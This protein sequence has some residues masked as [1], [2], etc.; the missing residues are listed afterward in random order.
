[1]TGQEPDAAVFESISR[2]IA[3]RAGLKQ[4]PGVT[5]RLPEVVAERLAA[6]DISSPSL[7]L[8][9]LAGVSSDEEL[10]RLTAL[11]TV[12]ETHFFRDRAQ[13]NLLKN[14]ILP[15]LMETGEPRR[16]LRILSAGCSTG[17]EPYSI[18]MLVG[19]MFRN[20]PGWE[21]SIFGVDIDEKAI[22][23]AEAGVYTDWSFRGT[24]PS[25]KERYF[26][27]RAD[28]WELDQR[29]RSMVT[30]RA[31]NLVEDDYPSV[32]SGIYDIDL[33]VCRNVFIYFNR[34]SVER[35]FKKLAVSLS[36]IGYLLTGHAEALGVFTPG[37][38]VRMFPESVVYQ[39]V[40]RQEKRRDNILPSPSLTTPSLPSPLSEGRA[41][42]KEPSPRPYPAKREREKASPP[43]KRETQSI[44]VSFEDEIMSLIRNGSFAEAMSKA[45]GLDKPGGKNFASVFLKAWEL[46]NSGDYVNAM[47]GLNEAARINPLEPVTYYLM[48]QIHQLEC[49]FEK[50]KEKLRKTLYLDHAFIPAHLELA[51]LYERDNDAIRARKSRL[52]ALDA[53]DSMPPDHRYGWYDA[54]M[55]EVIVSIK[56][57]L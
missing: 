36:D 12:R 44:P 32:A 24:D 34:S 49:E 8:A 26:R 10:R 57:L 17:E 30:F 39:R 13:F 45:D 43:A 42:G 46:A 21:I 20:R 48:S 55:T 7:Y 6:L 33:A 31:M 1:M 27:K 29:I 3:E 41:R 28:E 2:V 16:S 50:A 47:D 38:A 15:R 37:L 14:V 56:S 19:E 25:L 22:R 40:S 51:S 23:K 35:V 4:T 18:A 9:R 53:L 5:G 52:A 54:S 11:L